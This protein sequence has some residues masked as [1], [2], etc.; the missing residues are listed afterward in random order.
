MEIGRTCI[1]ESSVAECGVTFQDWG[2]GPS[3]FIV[4]PRS[5]LG[6]FQLRTAWEVTI[7]CTYSIRVTPNFYNPAMRIPQLRLLRQPQRRCISHSLRR[8]T[9]AAPIVHIDNATFYRQYPSATQ[10]ADG[11][12]NPAIFPNLTFSLPAHGSSTEQNEHWS[13]LSPSSLARTTFLQ[14]LNGQYICLPPTAR[15]Y[16]YLSSAEVKE[17]R[18]H[19]PQTAIK[20]VGFD[21]E[22]GGL[23]GTSLKGAYLSARYEARKEETDWSLM[24]YLTGHTELNALEKGRDEVDEALLEKVIRDLKLGQLLDMPVGNLSNGQTRRARIAKALMLR[25][26]L[27]LLDGPFMGLDPP[28]VKMLSGVLREMADRNRP[29]LVLSLRPEDHIPD[30]ISHL[31]YVDEELRPRFTGPKDQVLDALVTESETTTTVTSGVADKLRQHNTLSPPTRENKQKATTQLSRDGFPTHSPPSAPGEAIVTMSGV[32]VRYGTKTVLG[33]WPHGLHW[34]VHRNQRWGIFG[35][36]GSGK[37]TLLSLITSDHP[38]TYSLPIKLFGRSRLPEKGETGISLFELQR[39]IGHS[40]PEVHTFFPKGLSV[41]R[42]LMSAWADAPMAR[43][44]LGVEEMGRVEACLRWFAAELS[45][46]GQSTLSSLSQKGGETAVKELQEAITKG[47]DLAWAD[48]LTFR[49]LSFGSQRLALFLRAIVAGQ[50]LVILDEAFSGIDEVI[51][52]KCLLFLSHGEKVTLTTT[53]S[54]TTGSS[55]A[56]GIEDTSQ[57]KLQPSLVAQANCVRIEGLTENQALVVISHAPE[58][59]PGAVRQWICLPEPGEGKPARWGNLEGPLELNSKGWEQI[60]G[61]DR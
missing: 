42:A 51:R 23:G 21:A 36:N 2:E 41:R 16:P 18:L 30:W 32:T 40:S 60:W 50:E 28:T 56:D 19:N 58:D 20:Y 35:P 11:P 15:S 49:D 27:L 38:Q 47:D 10:Q 24:D 12:P 44:T 14:I 31:V 37:T 6:S 1:G 54:S 45:P 53:T 34:N 25:P 9:K 52:D 59:V 26:E 7:P 61:V 8:P 39:R 4:K 43:P 57:R 13:I 3:S 46:N 5:A 33:D 29:R 17:N 55:T 22:R 48:K